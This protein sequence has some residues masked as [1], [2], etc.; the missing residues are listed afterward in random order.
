MTPRT[1][2]RLSVVAIL[3]FLGLAYVR[4]V[5][6][7]HLFPEPY[8]TVLL[9]RD[10]QL[11]GA[12]TASD[13]QWRFPLGDSIPWRFRTC[14]LEF[15]DRHFQDHWGVNPSSLARATVQNFRAGRVVSGGSTLTMQVA[16]LGRGTRSRSWFHK[17]DEMLL[18][19]RL[20]SQLPKDTILKLYCAHAPFGGNVV[21]L[22]AAAWRYY[23]RPAHTLS[24]AEC[25]TLAVLPN[26]PSVVYPGRRQTVLRAKRDRLLQRL[27]DAG[28]IDPI[29]LELARQEE[30]P[31]RP[32]SLPRLAP[33]LLQTLMA[34]GHAGERIHTT[35][36]ASIQER[37]KEVMERHAR[38]LHANEVHNA[39]ALILETT[40]G[41]VV[42]YVGNLPDAGVLHQGE[43]DVVQARRSTGSLLKPFLYADMMGQGEILPGMLV[44]DIPTRFDRFTPRNT[45][46][47]FAGAVRA[48][49]ALARSLN[50]PAVR[51]LHQHGVERTLIMLQRMGL[52]HLDKPAAYYGLALAIGGG[53]STLLELTGAY[54]SLGRIVT[55]FRPG[56]EQRL[57]WSPQ[58]LN[59]ADPEQDAQAAP[60]DAAAA[61]L[62][63]Q[64]LQH[65]KRPEAEQGWNYFQG[66]SPIAWKTGTS[67][68]NRDAWAIGVTAAHTIGVWTGNA[69]GEG[70]P[71]LTGT[72]AAAPM[73]FEL[74]G[75]L[76]PSA[77]LDPPHDQLTPV[78]VCARSG[79]RAG[80]FCGEPEVINAPFLGER[81][82]VCP[83]HQLIHVDATGHFRT[84][85]FGS[86]AVH[87]FVLPP[88]MERYTAANDPSHT[89]LPPWRD[90]DVEDSSPY[91]EFIYPLPHTRVHIPRELTGEAG[92]VVLEAAHRH[93]ATPIHWHLDGTFIGSTTAEHRLRVQPAPGE[94]TL[95]LTDAG[96]HQLLG[97]F[98]VAAG[99]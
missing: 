55:D 85:E 27:M 97:K 34:Q 46:R 31:G 18:A 4:W 82:A 75:L 65:V 41:R 47:T 48:D 59:A 61:Y 95:T 54:A 62:T 64:A 50:V 73:L 23:G 81:A 67:V 16:R 38:A 88:A 60:L 57:V 25:A 19:I 68:G 83:Y 49:A 71:G 70:R 32:L 7:P 69:T 21:G 94:H 13:G 26:A 45:D 77:R 79:F 89:S 3:L 53:E 12:I 30:L 11:L 39:A 9:D 76:P 98:F 15:E 92:A 33:H 93:P 14:L 37:S 99:P 80:P 90:A 42:A 43:V 78:E 24:W 35:L 17:M 28:H 8:S 66:R 2:L 63:L 58:L 96:G 10:G 51:A 86:R 74:F 36:I 56:E 72:L 20:E 29:E 91:M 87:W 1:R 5:P 40:T 52:A 84:H 22:E 44:A 6:L